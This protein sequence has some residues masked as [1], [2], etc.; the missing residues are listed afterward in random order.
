[1]LNKYLSANYLQS[2]KMNKKDRFCHKLHVKYLSDEVATA[3]KAVVEAREVM[4]EAVRTAHAAFMDICFLELAD[5]EEVVEEGI[6][7]FDY[8]CD[9][10]HS[11]AHYVETER[12]MIVEQKAFKVAEQVLRDKKKELRNYRAQV[13]NCAK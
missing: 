9:V 13:K 1:M 5:N 3:K 10:A 2:D 7:F 4:Y 11:D 12:N 8:L 6:E